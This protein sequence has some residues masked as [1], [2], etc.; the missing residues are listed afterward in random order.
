MATEDAKVN[1][2]ELL[3]RKE[4]V[5]SRLSELN[6]SAIEDT[7]VLPGSKEVHWDLVMK[8]MVMS[9]VMLSVRTTCQVNESCRH[10]TSSAGWRMTFNGRDCGI[11]AMQRKSQKR[12]MSFTRPKMLGS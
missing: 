7:Q 10:C 1:F 11:S 3:E 6:S 12:W 8:E 5:R 9:I 2:A 4:K